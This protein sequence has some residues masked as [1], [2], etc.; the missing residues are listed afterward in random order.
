MSMISEQIE[1]LRSE[2]EYECHVSENKLLADTL[3]RA[4]D[5]IEMLSEK[6]REPMEWIPCSERLP[7]VGEPVLTFDGG[8]ICVE[9]RIE[10]IETPDGQIEGEWWIDAYDGDEFDPI[11]LRDGTAIAWMPLP[12]PYKGGEL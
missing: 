7:E 3:S 4:A 1:F 2:A 8:C 9:R 6:V 11:D 5:T 12:E 10:F